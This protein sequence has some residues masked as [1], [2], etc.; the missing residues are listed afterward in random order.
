M[1][2]QKLIFFDFYGKIFFIQGVNSLFRYICLC[3]LLSICLGLFAYCVPS[4]Y[5]VQVGSESVSDGGNTDD[6]DDYYE[7]QNPEDFECDPDDDTNCDNEHVDEMDMPYDMLMDTV[8]YLTCDSRNLPDDTF[9]FKVEALREGGVRL[10]AK[11]GQMEENE[12]KQYP[13]HR[14]YPALIPIPPRWWVHPST[15]VQYPVPGRF[16]AL[17]SIELEDYL[18]DFLEN[19]KIFKKE[20]GRDHIQLGWKANLNLRY[21]LQSLL[22]ASYLLVSFYHAGRGS[23]LLGYRDLD[24][25]RETTHGRYYRVDLSEEEQQYTLSDITERYEFRTEKENSWSCGLR[26]KVRRHDDHRYVGGGQPAE[27]GCEDND[28]GSAIY[29]LVRQV[30]GDD[31]NIDPEEYCVSLKNRRKSCYRYTENIHQGTRN[32]NNGKGRV[33]HFDCTGTDILRLCPH[34]LSICTRARVE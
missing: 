33:D 19:G 25:D 1:N 32:I 24:G 13:Y 27:P 28:D 21:S 12:I 14:S 3:L 17:P 4:L 16:G 18:D 11:F 5:T 10:R 20:F 22:E 9:A 30:L 31:W 26:F 6:Y 2:C 29:R 23:S 7:G 15:E 34:Y 8:S